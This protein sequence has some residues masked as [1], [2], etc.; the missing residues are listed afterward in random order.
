MERITI[1]TDF[2]KLDSC[3]K[4]ACLCSS[5]GEAKNII[6]DGLVSVDGEVCRQRGKKLYPGATVS[7]NGEKLIV[8]DG[9]AKNQKLGANTKNQTSDEDAKNQT[10]GETPKNPEKTP[11][12]CLNACK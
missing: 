4:L 12:D 1:T 11:A 7:Y 6:A 5:G 10:S 2:I 9:N 8:S 3:L